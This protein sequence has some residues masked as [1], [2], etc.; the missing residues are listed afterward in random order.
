MFIEKLNWMNILVSTRRV[1]TSVSKND[2]F[3]AWM[4]IQKFGNLLR[5]VLVRENTGARMYVSILHCRRCYE[6]RSSNLIQTDGFA[7]IS[8]AVRPSKCLS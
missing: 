6:L 3:T 5:R 2:S 7:L 1:C 4:S 8:L